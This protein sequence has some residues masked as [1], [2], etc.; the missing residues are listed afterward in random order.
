[1]I[2]VILAIGL[3]LRSFNLNQSLWL[4]EATQ[5]LLSKDSLN[6][7]IF[8]HGADFHPPLSYLLLHFWTYFSEFDIWLR[9]LSVIFGVLT[10][11]II[12]AFSLRVFNKNT[13]GLSAL[14]LAIAPYHIYYSQEIRMYSEATLFAVIS[15][16][17]FYLL[18]Q[19]KKFITSLI[20]ILSSLALIYT[21]YDG[22]FLF[23]AQLIYLIFFQ[24]KLLAFFL[25]RF[26]FILLFWLPWLPIFLTQ[27]K[28]GSNIDKYLPGWRNILSL[29][30]YKSIPLTFF[31]FSFGRIDFDNQFIYII[32]AFIIFSFFGTVLYKAIRRIKTR[33]EVLVALWFVVPLACAWLISLKVP[34]DQPFRILFILPAFYILL[35]KGLL[36]FKK[37]ALFFHCSAIGISLIGLSLYYFNPKYSREDWKGASK[38]VLD[39][40]TSKTLVVFA[41]PSPFP[42]YEYYAQNKFAIGV[43]KEFPAKLNQVNGNLGLME[44]K[45]EV[46]LFQYLV[47]LSDP[48]G[49]VKQAL[50]QKGFKQ[51]KVFN[52][53][54]VG[55][56][57]HF[58]R[59]SL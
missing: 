35:A 42:P 12:Y 14:L 17:S 2:W 1:M 29:S 24:K 44:D 5:V 52:F 55:F 48:Q 13:A 41:W 8:S 56:I 20:Y 16:C 27:L 19:E 59:N 34:I 11:W 10:I 40:S 28:A 39:N 9:L 37:Y 43:V 25:K 54:G 7:I 46:Y 51:E 23:A 18:T 47:G 21:H 36:S 32:V 58:I 31:K 26:L 4:D 45:K 3:L 30:F 38:F 49:V 22:F 33:E 50:E 53:R 15:M 6:N 57:Y